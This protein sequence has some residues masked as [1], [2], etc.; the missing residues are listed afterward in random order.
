[1]A[2]FFTF[3][4]YLQSFETATQKLPLLF[5]SLIA[6]L[7][8]FIFVF[9][10]AY[11]FLE[12]QMEEEINGCK[13]LLKK[14][15]SKTFIAE[16]HQKINQLQVQQKKI[17]KNDK[18]QAFQSKLKKEE[19]KKV[20]AGKKPFYMK[21]KDIKKLKQVEQYESL[22]SKGKLD[23]FLTRKRKKMKSRDSKRMDSRVR[24]N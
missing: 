17:K 4:K 5:L 22:K 9:F 11:K 10:E 7:L 12:T 18:K 24:R 8:N 21:K 13:K 23:A 14:A 15:K 2:V 1:V 19:Y 3:K 16:I 6:I 20:G